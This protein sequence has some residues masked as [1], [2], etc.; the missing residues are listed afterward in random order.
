METGSTLRTTKGYYSSER[1]GSS[2]KQVIQLGKNTF[3]F[4]GNLQNQNVYGTGNDDS[5]IK[6][7]AS[8]GNSDIRSI[9]FWAD[10]DDDIDVP[11][12]R[13]FNLAN[14]SGQTSAYDNSIYRYTNTNN[15]TNGIVFS[16]RSGS[17]DSGKKTFTYAPSSYSYF[18]RHHYVFVYSSSGWKLYIDGAS[19]NPTTGSRP[20]TRP[21]ANRTYDYSFF[22]ISA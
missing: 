11:A 1:V 5:Y 10:P 18:D 16:T 3:R 4:A 6:L 14:R 15:N 12:Q 7:N 20:T 22:C 17:T 2:I 8:N 19:V 9:A 21:A 13:I